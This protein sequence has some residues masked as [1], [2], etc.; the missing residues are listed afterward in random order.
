LPR[1]SNSPR[2]LVPAAVERE[3]LVSYL[4]VF[5]LILA[6]F[7]LA[8]HVTFVA[9]VRAEGSALL[10]ELV[11]AGENVVDTTKATVSV[12][13]D[14]ATLRAMKPTDGL[15]WYTAAGELIASQGLVAPRSGVTDALLAAAEHAV[16][17]GAGLR[18][19]TVP[20]RVRER[21][22]LYVFIRASVSDAPYDES[23]RRVDIGIVVGFALAMLGSLVAGQ[24]L[25]RRA[26]RRIEA[27][28]RTLAD[29]TAD[30][31][32]ELRG[33]LTAI[34]A[35]AAAGTPAGGGTVMLQRERLASIGSAAAQMARLTDDLLI[36]ARANQ[37]LERELFVV[38]LRLR[39]EHIAELYRAEA[40]RSGIALAARITGTPRVYGNPHQIDRILGNLVE[41]AIRFTGPGGKVTMT[42]R[43]GRAGSRVCVSDTGIGIA[44]GD[45]GRVFER[46][47]RAD[48]NRATDGGTGLG[49]AIAQALA[50]RHGGDISVSSTRGKGS[51]FTVTF[52][53]RPR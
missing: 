22:L 37:S 11:R 27:S 35:N 45:L 42:C 6:G 25:A 40:Q 24:R 4:A 3:L 23:I 44:A 39:V 34:T 16:A 10:D 48:P 18:T 49:L 47:W 12:D 38:D 41:N 19:L 51:E 9:I 1:F 28:M 21:P 8:V 53:S 20:Y 17:R 52:P 31:A 26:I 50:R 13:L 46:F 15:Q 32:H 5:A 33:P 2:R 7:A 29:F 30:A 14:D 43:Q 36:L